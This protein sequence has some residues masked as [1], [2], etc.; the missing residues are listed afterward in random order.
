MLLE[1][2]VDPERVVSEL[3]RVGKRGYIETP[4]PVW[5]RLHGT[6][7]HRWVVWTDGNTLRFRAKPGPVLD[8]ELDAWRARA[9]VDARE[10]ML[11]LHYHLYEA[12]MVTEL[13]WER[14]ITVSVDRS[15]GNGDF[16]AAA[17]G[18]DEWQEASGGLEIQVKQG[19]APIRRQSDRRLDLVSLLACTRCGQTA[20]A[21]RGNGATLRRLRSGRAGR[22]RSPR[23]H[24]LTSA[25]F[26][27]SA[28]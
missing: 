6:P 4:S 3:T 20:R 16:V 28:T 22:S 5:E 21:R 18:G 12:G 25:L 19:L 10:A 1:H 26:S 17:G 27:A 9:D 13:V 8:A 14:S 7:Y 15:A 2:V 23:L 24:G 11:A